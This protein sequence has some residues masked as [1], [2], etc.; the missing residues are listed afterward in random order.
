MP[1]QAPAGKAAALAGG[2][3]APLALSLPLSR[4]LVGMS[5]WS[6]VLAPAEL[7]DF[8]RGIKLQHLADKLAALGYDDVDDFSSYDEAAR[9][10][11]R[12]GA[13]RVGHGPCAMETTLAS[14][15]CYASAVR[16]RDRA[17]PGDSRD[18]RHDVTCANLPFIVTSPR[19]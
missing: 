11:L 13:A 10:R 19:G 16:R 5:G 2:R 18:V 6:E 12:V 15:S 17:A 1:R 7:T 9:E 3:F 14:R 8:L 4:P